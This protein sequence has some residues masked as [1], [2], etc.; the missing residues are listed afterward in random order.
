MIEL[1]NTGQTYW[2]L[3]M[4]MTAF[5]GLLLA[6]RDE[7]WKDAADKICACIEKCDDELYTA[8]TN[9]KVA[10]GSGAMYA[11]TGDEKFGKLSKKIWTWVMETQTEDGVWVRP[12]QYDSI[13][14][15]PLDTT[16]D[17]SLERAC[18]MFQ[19]AKTLARA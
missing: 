7:K 5:A 13:D 8:I 4:S 9:G 15:Q 1:G 10:W 2:Y 12:P 16:I 11:A 19:L 3:G 18:Y 14:E 6:T 17:T